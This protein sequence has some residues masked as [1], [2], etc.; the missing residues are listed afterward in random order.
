MPS[1]TLEE[2]GTDA[3]LEL[4]DLHAE[5]RLRDV[6]PSGGATEVQLLSQHHERAEKSRL[7]RISDTHT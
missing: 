2:L 5:G 4:P 7:H 3:L 1:I 6:E